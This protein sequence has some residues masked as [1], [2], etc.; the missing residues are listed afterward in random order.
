LKNLGKIYAHI[1][2][3]GGSKRVPAKNLRHLA[4]KPLIGYAIECAKG[5]EAFDKIYVNSD[6]APILALADAYGVEQ[7][8]RD[9]WLAGDQAQGDDFTAD[10]IE[11]AN[12]DTLVMISPVCPLVTPED[13]R[14]ALEAFQN[15][16]CDTLI[17]C[18]TTQMQT[19]CEEKPVNIDDTKALGP[20]QDNPVVQILNWAVT[21]WD[22][23]VFIETYRKTKSGYLG[24]K[25][26]LFP[27]DP[28]HSVKIS[29]EEDFQLAETLLN[30]RKSD[31]SNSA[32][33]QYWKIGDPV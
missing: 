27:L 12:P 29:H 3:R 15:S 7:Y 17:S 24:T 10:F 13:V 9:D 18:S 2:A 21:I 32:D 22:P 20:S 4:G 30:A 5:V 33:I 23:Q 26:M 19:F 11:K 6:S 14:S 1:P 31:H 28:L 8:K 25:R 16:D